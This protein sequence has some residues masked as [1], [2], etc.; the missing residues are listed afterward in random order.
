MDKSDRRR[1]PFAFDKMEGLVREMKDEETGVR[2]KSQ[3][4]FLTSIPSAFAGY[5]IIEWLMDRLTVDETEAVHI[6]NMLCQY[7]YFFPVNDSKNLTL[8]DDSSLYRFQIPYYWPCSQKNPDNVEYAIYL[9]KRLLRNK[10]RHALEDYEMDSLN[11]LKKNLQNKWE[12]ITM[13]SEEQVRLS[14]DRKKGEKIVTDSQERAF[15]RVHRPPPGCV[16]VLEQ[17]PIKIGGSF[18]TKKK[19]SSEDLR[20]E[21]ELLRNCI[22]RTR[23]K[24]SVALDGLVSFSETYHEYDPLLTA[25][26]PSNPWVT[27]DPTFWTFNCPIVDAIT[28]KRIKR[29]ALSMEDL[30]SDL[31]GLQEFTNYLRKEYSHENIRFWLAVNDL[32][33]SCQSQIHLKVKEI[34]NEFLAPGAPCEINIDGKTMEKTH[35]EMKGP[36]R[37]TFDAAAE[38]VYTLLLKKDCYPR[39]IRSEHYKNLLANGVQPSARRRFFGFVG[40]AAN[41][42]DCK[43]RIKPG[44]STSLQG[45]SSSA[46]QANQSSSCGSGRRRGSDRSLTSSPHELPINVVKVSQSHS[47]S[48]LSDIPYRENLSSTEES[49]GD[50]P[51]GI[52]PWEGSENGGN[53]KKRSLPSSIAEETDSRLSTSSSRKNS[54]SGGGGNAYDSASADESVSDS[55]SNRLRRSCGLGSSTV[56]NRRGSSSTCCTPQQTIDRPSVSSA[57]DLDFGPSPENRSPER[58]HSIG[59]I[60]PK[61]VFAEPQSTLRHQSSAECASTTST[62]LDSKPNRKKLL[63]SLSLARKQSVTPVINVSSVDKDNKVLTEESKVTEPAETASAFVC[64]SED[65]GAKAA[66]STTTSNDG[67]DVCPWEDEQNQDKGGRFLKVYETYGFL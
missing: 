22:G 47:Q 18:S 8:K 32:K 49:A 10:Q 20:R 60:S 7:G 35:K 6:A 38:H 24:T 58:Q 5:N 54:T 51:G 12:F 62:V 13:Q 56:Y 3:K 23:V 55:V 25:A 15:W 1:R 29:W 50:R 14:K 41:K 66:V 48:N 65:E 2:V 16:S 21:V 67:N 45:T 30:V 43:E 46:L 4:L 36:S 63:K 34:Y 9:S 53:D 11:S 28:E 17:I 37:F 61:N 57:E 52:C 59:P 42:K 31:T 19:R 39:F 33:R 64:Q 40:G 27:D 44:C 26:Q